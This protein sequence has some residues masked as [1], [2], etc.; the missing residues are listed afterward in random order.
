MNQNV[1]GKL[2]DLVIAIL[3][4]ILFPLLYFGFQSD[5]ITE[6]VTQMNTSN[7]VDNVSEHGMLTDT[8]YQ[9]YLTRLSSTNLVYEIEMEHEHLI[10]EPE[11]R[12]K[13]A[14]EI[15]EEQNSA[16]TGS[17]DYTYE[18]VISDKPEVN[19]EVEEGIVNSETNESVL[20][21]SVDIPA[22]PYHV[23]TDA[24]YAGTKHVHTGSSSSGTG[25][26][27]GGKVTEVSRECGG[28]FVGRF[29]TTYYYEGSYWCSSCGGGLSW[30]SSTQD[31]GTQTRQ[32][33]TCGASNTIS[34]TSS[35]R[36]WYG[37][38]TGCSASSVSSI[39]YSGT[40]HTWTERTYL[41]NCGKTTGKYYDESGREVV[42]MCNLII[43]S[44]LATHPVQTKYQGQALITTARATYLDGSTKVIICSTD[45]D[46]NTLCNSR[47]ISIYYIGYNS[48]KT[49]GRFTTNI[50]VT[51]L[52][53]TSLCTYGH[54]YRLNGDGSDPSCPYCKAW[55]KNLSIVEP[56]SRKLTITKGTS[57]WENGVVL[58]AIYFDGR[59][60]YVH[61][62]YLDNL[63]P[64][65]VGIQNVTIGFKGK[66]VYLQVTSKP[67]QMLCD[68][69]GKYYDLY[70]DD[71]DPGCTYCKA[72][73]PVFTGKILTY[74]ETYK[75]EEILEVME[76]EGVYLFS[77]GDLFTV[78]VQSKTHTLGG[79]LLRMVYLRSLQD[80]VF[81][82][83][84]SH[85]R[86]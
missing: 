24:C 84:S 50:V 64:V 7:F 34:S 21:S 61:T 31:V 11:Y 58:I 6:N 2:L 76:R 67:K 59:S 29:I 82:V 36:Q 41:L 65:Y 44:I 23:H 48:T 54:I 43:V 17:N 28:Y 35:F 72:L 56:S 63:D 79:K 80:D 1:L 9:V 15:K 81:A 49:T 75:E 60:E 69:C 38:C 19:E 12:F 4:M 22:N 10:Y 27:A 40:K 8:M 32:C 66:Y 62:G 85:I 3:I 52:P 73:I 71:T 30:I 26:Y 70:P 86:D 14:E 57:L 51:I 46:T 42:H 45:F 5:K 18:E 25:C 68:I 33:H 53:R 39:D 55:V 77:R 16:Y 20:A 47:T 74:Y 83:Y 13:T 37:N 78:K